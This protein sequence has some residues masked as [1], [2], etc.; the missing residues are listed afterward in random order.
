MM[1]LPVTDVGEPPVHE[2]PGADRGVPD[3]GEDHEVTDG[4]VGYPRAQEEVLVG[5]EVARAVEQAVPAVLEAAVPDPN[6][7]GVEVNRVQ[8]GRGV[9]Q[10]PA[11]EHGIL[12]LPVILGCHPHAVIGVLEDQV[13]RLVIGG[14]GVAVGQAD[15]GLAAPSTVRRLI[16]AYQASYWNRVPP[17]GPSQRRAVVSGSSPTTAHMQ[18]VWALRVVLTVTVTR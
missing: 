6:V 8:P 11:A 16:L 14:E 13:G 18:S 4:R 5:V 7:H 10:E 1:R 3:Q 17:A 9:A 2:A 12:G 15:L